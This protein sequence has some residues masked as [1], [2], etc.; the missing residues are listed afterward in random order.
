MRNLAMSIIIPALICYVL[1][2]IIMFLLQGKILFHPT[3]YAGPPAQYGLNDFSEVKI[4]TEDGAE[5]SGWF[6]KAEKPG[7]VVLFFYG[8]ADSLQNYPD[9]F[10]KLSDAGYTVLGLNYR[11]YAGT[12]G[13][14]TETNLYEDGK[15]A[16]KFLSQYD[17]Q[18][19]II[20]AG[21]SLGTGVAVEMAAH[22]KLKGLV[23][24]SPYTSMTNIAGEIYW[25]MP[26]KYLARYKFASIDKIAQVKEPILIIH[27]RQDKL[28]P[29]AHAER[30]LAAAT[31]RKELRIYENDDH[32][33]VDMNRVGDDI[34]QFFGNT[35]ADH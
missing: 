26:V 19:N 6:K 30:L 17:E 7:K 34:I 4:P 22:H 29:L 3:S 28:I 2:I 31:S 8:N 25:Y 27:G 24:I 13:K 10:K 14:P 11:G 15:A 23:L 16:I 32:N 9:F 12:K 33:D 21:R 20:F 18:K 5:I 1:L 35:N